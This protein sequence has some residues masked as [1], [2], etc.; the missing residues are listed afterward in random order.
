MSSGSGSSHGRHR[1]S[2]DLYAS[3]PTSDGTYPPIRTITP[4]SPELVNPG[5]D[6]SHDYEDLAY[7]PPPPPFLGD[8]DYARSPSMNTFASEYSHGEAP[9]RL[10]G[11][12]AHGQTQSGTWD[13]S[14]EGGE[15]PS[16]HGSSANLNAMAYRNVAGGQHGRSESYLYAKE[17]E[18]GL[19]GAGAG[20]GTLRKRGVA[21]GAAG[22]GW[23]SSKSSRSKKLWALLF[24][25]IAILIVAIAVAVPVGITQSRKSAEEKRKESNDGTEKGIPTAANPVADWHGAPYGGNGSTVYLEDGSSFVY[26]NSFGGYWVAIPFN[27]TARAQRDVPRLNETWDYSKHLISGV[28]LGGWLV[29]EPFIVPGMFEPFNSNDN[30]PNATNNAIDEWT[31]SEQLGSN[32]TAAM[33]EHYETWITEKDFAEIAGA[34]L[35]WVRIPIGWWA[36][37]TW[38]DSPNNEPFLAGVAWQYFLKAIGWARKYGLRINL[39][40][41][42]VPGSQNGYNHS[43]KLGSINFLNG[44]MGVANA[45]RTLDYIRTF[46]EFISQPEYRNVVPMFSVLNE[47]YAATIGADGLRSFYLETYNQMRAIT[48][49][50]EGNGPFLTFHDGF[51]TLGANY[52]SGGWL[53]YLNGWDRVAMDS[54][55]YLCFDVPNNWGLG[56]Q[57]SLPCTYWAEYMNVTTNQFGLTMGAEW[58]LAVNDCGK[59]LNNV[60]NGARY[61]GTYYNPSNKTAPQYE[62]VGT[63][64]DWINWESWSQETKDGLSGVASAHMDALRHWFFWTW[65][66]GYSSDLGKIANPMWNYQLGLEQGWVPKNPRTAIGTCATVVEQ[67]GVANQYNVVSAPTLAP[68]MTGGSG[69][70]SITD[71]AMSSTYS[72]FPFTTLGTGNAAL[73]AATLPT[74]TPTG[75]IIT[76]SAPAQPTSWPSGYS[77]SVD[78]GS[79]WVQS[80]DTAGFY[81]PA[82]DCSYVDPWSGVSYGATTGAWC[83]GQSAAA[84][85]LQATATATAT[86]TDAAAAT[87]TDA[88]AA[89][90]TTDADAAARRMRRFVRTT[91]APTAAPTGRR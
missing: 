8:A 55:R 11:G 36:I 34:G 90:D 84:A 54:H 88:A 58:S 67:Q 48:G 45:Q 29:L 47:P 25:L 2:A 66:T 62:A 59:W 82:A 42:A 85:S 53:G 60:G 13:G 24:A 63:C 44:V 41:H 33:T 91:P 20:A 19:G 40:F 77:S 61:D 71:Q 74:Y 64:D 3:V 27:D 52:T 43:G 17:G 32:L 51:I 22:S 39:D 80:T 23:W 72:A 79:G 5:H 75:S 35:N 15:S 30:S 18:A 65:K 68:W 81:K 87:A 16:L 37:E 50:G 83:T 6:H 1:S 86:A 9:Y 26:N 10:R 38:T 31:L 76:M 69:A 49:T 12:A 14:H 28:N 70:G 21:P 78:V 46:T 56:Y 4:R 7:S 57:A 89:D 73:N